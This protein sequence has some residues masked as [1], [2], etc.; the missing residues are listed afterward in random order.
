MMTQGRPKSEVADTEFDAL[1]DAYAGRVLAFARRLCGG[2]VAEAEDLTQDTFV[3]AWVGRE[4][5]G[6][7]AQRLTWLL[8]IA[9]RRWRDGRRTPHAEMVSS[10][11]EAS[12]DGFA[13]KSLERLALESALA[14]LDESLRAAWLL[15]ASQGLTHKEAAEVLSRPVG[16]VKW[17]VATANARLRAALTEN[18]DDAP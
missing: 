4:T 16:T 2:S 13:E 5:F 9:V 8:G 15:V 17:Q 11:A 12:D 6:G 3:A 1:F 14:Q 18:T 10:P 7:R